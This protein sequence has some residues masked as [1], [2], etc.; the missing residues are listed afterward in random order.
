MPLSEVH[1]FVYSLPQESNTASNSD[2]NTSG[3]E[4]HT[5]DKDSTYNPE[6][7]GLS[8]QCETGL[9]ESE[10]ENQTNTNNYE[11]STCQPLLHEVRFQ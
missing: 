9:D 8:S 2:M 5:T 1:S 4:V 3:S 7:Y 6:E 10:N 11:P